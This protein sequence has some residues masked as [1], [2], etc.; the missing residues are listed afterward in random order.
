MA[1]P[2]VEYITGRLWVQCVHLQ[3]IHVLCVRVTWLFISETSISEKL[4]NTTG[5]KNKKNTRGT[6]IYIFIYH[7][8][9]VFVDKW[10]LT[11]VGRKGR[12][13]LHWGFVF[14]IVVSRN[15]S[16]IY[17]YIYFLY[18]HIYYVYIRIHAL[19]LFLYTYT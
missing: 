19:S 9:W 3:Y 14:I 16:K 17:V 18:I 12:G 2:S 4:S 15:Y 6:S 1:T 13:R 5:V 7:W 11:T 10:M 8:G